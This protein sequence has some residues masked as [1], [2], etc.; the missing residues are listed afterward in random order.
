MSTPEPARHGNALLGAL[1]QLTAPDPD[2]ARKASPD[3]PGYDQTRIRIIQAAIDLMAEHGSQRLRFDELGQRLDLNRTT[4]YRYFDSK[5]DLVAAAMLVLM[6][7]ITE[8]VIR[9]T[10]PIRTVTPDTFTDN[11]YNVIHALQTN[12]R[13]R[14]IMD[15]RNIEQFTELS[16]RHMSEI[17]TTIMARYLTAEVGDQLRN[18]LDLDEVVHWLFHQIMSYGFFGLKGDTETEQKAYLRRMVVPVMFK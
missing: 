5:Q 2:S 8:A 16:K 12:D 18:D 9:D 15:A 4:I 10:S 7:E 11:L 3:H 6:I 17:T 14:V 1:D 13:Y